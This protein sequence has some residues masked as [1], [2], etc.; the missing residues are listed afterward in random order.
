LPALRTFS[1][2]YSP[3]STPRRVL[4][5]FP[6]RR[7]SDIDARVRSSSLPFG[8]VN[9]P[10]R[11]RPCGG[12][13]QAL[14]PTPHRF[15]P[16]PEGAASRSRRLADRKSTRLNASHLGTSFAVFCLKSKKNV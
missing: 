11:D 2:L 16:N 14:G 7:S 6:T 1:F 12:C 5:S 3:R 10:K 13:R 15:R 4:P 8:L 9:H